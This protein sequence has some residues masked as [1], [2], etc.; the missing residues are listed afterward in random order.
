MSYET[1]AIERRGAVATIWMDRPEVFNAFNEQ[2]IAELAA[3]CTELDA[4]AAVRVVV[5][6]GRGKH[7]SAGADLNWMRRAADSTEAE[8]LA[9]S[10]KFAAMLRAL[11]GLSKPT[12]ARVQGAAL[13]GGTGLAA[14][15]DMAIA[16][17]DAS[18][19]TSEVKFGIIPAVISPYV[20]RAIGPRHALRYFQSA[21]RFGALEAKAMGLVNEVVT[22]DELDAAVDRLV[23]ALLACGPQAQLAAKQ[24]IAALT[25]RPIDDAVGEETATR[26]A[27]QRAT[28][29]AREGFAAFFDKRAPAW[30]A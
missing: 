8:N 16:A 19:A 5:L 28:A 17:D 15:C 4:D 26:I 10:R 14:A 7:F 27:R 18:F 11:S 21:E 6:A 9:D 13:G 22:L 2:L 20:L 12:I 30:M 1:L 25:G 24:L 23:Q 3:A 29:E